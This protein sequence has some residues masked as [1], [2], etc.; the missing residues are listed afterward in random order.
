[1]DLHLRYALSR[2]KLVV[3]PLVKGS[4]IAESWK[5]PPVK[6]LLKLY[7]FNITNPVVFQ[8]PKLNVKPVLKEVGPYLY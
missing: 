7:F 2:N 1:M 8:N 6:P 5:A 4:R 3:Y